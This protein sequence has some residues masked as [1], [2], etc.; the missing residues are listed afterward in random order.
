MLG[1]GIVR[2]PIGVCPCFDFFIK[3]EMQTRPD[4]WGGF[5]I[6]RTSVVA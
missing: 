6:A 2:I 4:H 3:K 1:G 5:F